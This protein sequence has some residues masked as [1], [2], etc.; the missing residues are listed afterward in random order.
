MGGGPLVHMLRAAHR[1]VGRTFLSAKRPMAD[2]NVRPTQPRRAITVEV[3]CRREWNLVTRA[4]TPLLFAAGPT[5]KRSSE[6]V[7][8]CASV[9]TWNNRKFTPTLL[10]SGRTPHLPVSG[11]R[12]VT[13]YRANARRSGHDP[14]HRRHPTRPG[15]QPRGRT[16]PANRLP[17]A[18]LVRGQQRPVRV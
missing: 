8:V 11:A 10:L 5:N 15:R 6:S 18:G 3:P 9:P 1:S 7:P 17:A 13:S 16:G 12:A 2:R 14:S 4:S